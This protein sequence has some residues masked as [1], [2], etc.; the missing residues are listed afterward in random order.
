MISVRLKVE[1]VITLLPPC[2]KAFSKI[3]ASRMQKDGSLALLCRNVC[4]LLR[5][6]LT[7]GLRKIFAKLQYFLRLQPKK[8]EK[9]TQSASLRR[10]ARA[11]ILTFQVINY[12]R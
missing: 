10:L 5:S 8:A 7:T 2:A 1:R 12:M 11:Q 3:G 6:W 9:D 4:Y